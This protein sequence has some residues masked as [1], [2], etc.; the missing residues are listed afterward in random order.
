MIHNISSSPR[1]RERAS[2]R[3]REFLLEVFGQPSFSEVQS[4]QLNYFINKSYGFSFIAGY[5][6]SYKGVLFHKLYLEKFYLFGNRKQNIA[7]VKARR[8]LM[9]K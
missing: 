8:R 5:G 6:I 7:S 9:N 3:I 2:D 4:L 1:I